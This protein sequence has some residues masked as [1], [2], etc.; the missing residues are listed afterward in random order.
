MFDAL[1]DSVDVLDMLPYE[2]SDAGVLGDGLK[3]AVGQLITSLRSFA[4]AVV[5]ERFGDMRN[6]VLKDICEVAVLDL[7]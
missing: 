7:H 5:D 4:R 2:M 3:C 1:N 6:L